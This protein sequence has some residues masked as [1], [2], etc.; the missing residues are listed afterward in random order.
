MNFSPGTRLGPYEVVAPLGEGGMG[1]VYRAHDPRVGRDVAVK[2]LPLEVARDSD[3]RARFEREARAVAALSHPNILALHELAIAGEQLYVVTELLEGETLAD[4]LRQGALAPRKAVEIAIAIAHGLAAAHGKGI[5]HRDLKP[6]NVFLLADG[7][8]KI[9]D[10]GLA[11]PAARAASGAT[12]TQ[13]PLTDPGTVLGTVGYMAP[14]QVRGLD[15]DSR[16]DL[17]ALGVLLY[18]MLSGRRAFARETAAD[19]MTAVLQEDPPDLAP[20]RADLTPALER[21]VRHCLEKNPVERFQT[22]RDVIFALESLTGIGSGS[23]SQAMAERARGSGG[24]MV[25]AVAVAAAALFGAV[26]GVWLWPT[27]ASPPQPLFVSVGAPFH[28]FHTFAAP[29]IS[30]DGTTVVF[31]APDA[32]GDVQLWARDLRGPEARA[33]PGTRI[34]DLS[35][36][37]YQPSFSTDGKSLVVFLDNKVKRVFL[38][39]GSPQTLADAPEPRGSSWGSRDLIVYQ[40]NIGGPLYVVS[41]SGGTPR[42]L[43]DAKPIDDL[44][45]VARHPHFLPDGTHFVFN[46]L[47]RIYVASIEGGAPKLLVDV[48]SRAEYAAGYLWFVKNGDLMAQRFALESLSLV[49]EA[50]RVADRVGAN[51]SSPVDKAFSVSA[52]GVLVVWEEQVVPLSELVWLDR[53]GRRQG[54]VG[55]PWRI[56]GF[57]ASTDLTQVVAEVADELADHFVRARVIDVGR[58]ISTRLTLEAVDRLLI[59]TPVMGRDGR[60][61]FAVGVPDIFQ[62][63]LPSQ[64]PALLARRPLPW[65]SDVSRDGRWLLFSDNDIGG[66]SNIWALPLFRPGAEPDLYMVARD[67][68]LNYMGRF[69]PDGRWVAFIQNEGGKRDVHIDAFPGRGR[70][71]RV[72]PNGGSLPMWGDDGRKLY[73]MT[74][75]N[76]MMEVSVTGSGDDL[77]LSSPVDLFQAPIPNGG[78]SRPQYW[79]SPD[80]QRFLFNASIESAQPRTITVILNWPELLKGK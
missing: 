36:G 11:R 63:D 45:G 7:Q 16:A 19:T 6:A 10:F 12:L 59:L 75:D 24:A 60:R 3:R 56:S 37:I 25:W 42:A 28:R 61:V 52:A 32:K 40:P 57:W 73:Y 35:I 8:V 30:P 18:E 21:I 41:P 67:V 17:F 62:I 78:D 15:V 44:R 1:E 79:P 49:G 58:G 43:P 26:A 31:W 69:S 14:E 65:L 4:R 64:S 71:Q 2:V 48:G 39:G 23:R 74:P 50:V 29:A 27:T 76:R 20:T 38:D 77:R 5:V 47:A 33:L 55:E 66:R 34:S 70:R 51:L 53:A 46:D 54:I 80:G 72:S 9:L 22:A 68:S 13:A